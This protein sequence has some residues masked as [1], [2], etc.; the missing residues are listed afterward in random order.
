MCCV[1]SCTVGLVS[2]PRTPAVIKTEPEYSTIVKLSADIP[3][4]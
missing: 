4:E 1:Y 2:I 3:L